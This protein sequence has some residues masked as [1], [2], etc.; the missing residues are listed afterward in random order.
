MYEQSIWQLVKQQKWFKPACIV[1]GIIIGVWAIV[2]IVIALT[3]HTQYT[4][5]DTGYNTLRTHAHIDGDVLY[6]YAGGVF[7]AD[8]LADSEQSEILQAG[9]RLPDTVQ[10]IVWAGEHGALLFF[11]TTR[12]FTLIGTELD[13][14]ERDEVENDR[15]WYLDY[16][17]GGLT[18]LAPESRIYSDLAHYSN[19]HEAFY[20]FSG[21]MNV[22]IQRSLD[23]EIVEHALDEAAQ[24]VEYIGACTDNPDDVC[25]S[26]LDAEGQALHAYNIEDGEQQTLVEASGIVEPTSAR[27]LFMVRDLLE[28]EEASPLDDEVLGQYGDVRLY[29]AAEGEYLETHAAEGYVRP[30]VDSERPHNV[31]YLN[32]NQRVGIEYTSVSRTLFGTRHERTMDMAGNI[33]LVGF[34][35]WSSSGDKALAFDTGGDVYLIAPEGEYSLVRADED[36]VAEALDA[37]TEQVEEFADYSIDDGTIRLFVYPVDDDWSEAFREVGACLRDRPDAY[38]GYTFHFSGIERE[39]GRIAL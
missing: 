1:L 29:D 12:Q 10:N 9:M 3:P 4:A 20:Y 33:D 22:L 26:S 5:Y 14:R 34:L 30:L 28:Q 38:T 23:G 2:A 37:C 16:D 36:A 24:G 35:G 21:E 8:N 7:R 19:E 18:P 11:D 15:A 6:S 13:P 32:N 17:T 31:A 25:F 39:T 27:E